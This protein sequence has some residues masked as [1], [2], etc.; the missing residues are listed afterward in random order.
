VF[1]E[2]EKRAGVVMKLEVTP[3]PKSMPPFTI[4]GGD[5]ELKLIKGR[6]EVH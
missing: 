2:H 6:L 5:S 4:S 1:Y 3:S